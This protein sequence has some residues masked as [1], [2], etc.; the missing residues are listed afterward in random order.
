MAGKLL[1]GA[2]SGENHMLTKC[3]MFFLLGARLICGG[4][5]LF[6]MVTQISSV[7]FI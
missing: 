3:I 7:S 6:F 5:F 1:T 2:L 4:G